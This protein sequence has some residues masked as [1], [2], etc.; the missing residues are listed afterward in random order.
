MNNLLIVVDPQNDFI[1]GALPVK[2]AKE[3]M[4]N[5]ISHMIWEK[6]NI[7]DIMVT[8]DWHP[9]GHCSFEMNGG[10]WPIH[11]VQYTWGAAI[12]NNISSALIE[13]SKTNPFMWTT[14][15]SDMDKEEYGAFSN[16]LELE[17]L[18]IFIEEMEVD[19][20]QVAGIAGDYCVL[21]TLKN[22]LKVVPKEK[23]VVLT[24]CIASIDS[25]EKLEEFIIEN[26]LRIL[27]EKDDY[28]V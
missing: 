17:M 15:G 6:D 2:G 19:N 13:Y 8:L 3:A 9:I 16:H 21:E 12:A 25:G 23:I 10:N 7:S 14:K 24:D 26:N 5:L 28:E 4:Q 22:L 18:G 11:C 27:K 1:T 20:I